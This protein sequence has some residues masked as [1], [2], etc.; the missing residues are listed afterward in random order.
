MAI[1]PLGERQL[2]SMKRGNL[3]KR[4]SQYYSETRDTESVVEY[5][6]AVL[7]FNAITMDNYSFVCKD[8]FKELFMTAEPT[9][10]LRDYCLYFYD[11]FTYDEWEVVRDRL[12][13][14]RREFSEWTRKIRPETAAV[15][16][17]AAPT[18]K[19]KIWLYENYLSESDR[20]ENE[21]ERY[22]YAYHAAFRDENGRKIVQKFRNADVGMSNDRYFILLTTLMRLSIFQKN[23]IRRFHELEFR[24]CGRM[25]IMEFYAD[26]DDDEAFLKRRKAKAKKEQEEAQ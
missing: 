3:E 2:F 4:I 10:H 24:K 11:F 25:S 1:K 8:L 16:A 9:D 20:S 5:G 6:V 19:R 21:M 7:L 23:G 22:S 14:N 13:K 17:A 18:N 12:F 26:E 15:R